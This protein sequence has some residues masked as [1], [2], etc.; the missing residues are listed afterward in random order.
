[1]KALSGNKASSSIEEEKT[2]VTFDELFK[3]ATEISCDYKQIK[4]SLKDFVWEIK[5]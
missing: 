4:Q 5:R 1:M 3:D 2:E